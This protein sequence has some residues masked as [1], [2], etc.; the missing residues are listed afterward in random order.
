V[1]ALRVDGLRADCHGDQGRVLHVICGAI[2]RRLHL[3]I[4]LHFLV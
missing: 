1:W 2:L 4:K 3:L